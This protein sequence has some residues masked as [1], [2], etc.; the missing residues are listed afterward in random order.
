MKGL[1]GLQAEA[2]DFSALGDEAFVPSTRTRNTGVFVLEQARLAGTDWSAG[3]RTERVT[4][5]SDGGSRFGAAA[6]RRFSPTSLALSA[7]RA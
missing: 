6:S 5:D 2:L 7:V 4:V 1:V 3:A